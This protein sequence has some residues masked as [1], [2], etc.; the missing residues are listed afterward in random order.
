MTL[1]EI[2]YDV[3]E[4]MN[5]NSDDRSFDFPEP[6][7]LFVYEETRAAVLNQR[8]NRSGR[9]VDDA[10]YQT[11]IV[12]ME[13][14]DRS[15]CPAC[16]IGCKILR[17]T[18]QIPGILSLHSHALVDRVGPND[19][20]SKKYKF[21]EYSHVNNAFSSPFSDKYVYTFILNGYLFA[22]SQNKM[23]NSV[24]KMVVRAVFEEPSKFM[25][26]SGLCYGDCNTYPMVMKLHGD[27]IQYATQKLM[28]KYQ[29][30]EDSDNNA[31]PDAAGLPLPKPP[32]QAK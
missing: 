15:F 30:P 24:K 16:P 8:L 25:G 12:E 2:V 27:V 18:E 20:L 29:I 5:I 31:N 3:K 19:V 13:K 1:N 4:R 26:E 10:L 28:V 21:L 9:L 7:I 22:V 32:K 14:V 6:H 11:I 17:S 23:L